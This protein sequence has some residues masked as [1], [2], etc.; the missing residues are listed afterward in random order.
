M[1][2]L[3]PRLA[4]YDVAILLDEYRGSGVKSALSHERARF[5][6][7]GGSLVSDSELQELRTR[8]VSAAEKFNFGLD[9]GS[10]A[11]RRNF[12]Y[13]AGIILWD[14]IGDSPEALRDDVWS[15]ITTVVLSDIANWRYPGFKN[16]RYQGGVR[17]VF[18]RLWMRSRCLDRGPEH[19]DRWGLVSALSEDAL[20]AIT[21]RPAIGADP[22]LSGAVA[23]GWVRAAEKFGVSTMEDRMRSAIIRIRVGNLIQ[24]IPFMN[25]D[26][27][28]TLIDEAFGLR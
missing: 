15:F 16:E 3:Y 4:A 17:N 28:I 11:D 2:K 22:V 7:S 6:A 8:M 19:G 13:S 10:Q 21:E 23:E 1:S 5:G 20:V 27:R 14:W 9:A 26:E 25:E 24:L 18:Q 12:D